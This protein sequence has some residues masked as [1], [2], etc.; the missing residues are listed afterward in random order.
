[1]CGIFALIKLDGKYVSFDLYNGLLA[2]QHRG[3]DSAGIACL[4]EGKIDVVKDVGL[5]SSFFN[6]QNLSALKG[7]AGIAH[8]RYGTVGHT[9]KQDAHPVLSEGLAIAFNG[10]VANY[11]VLKPKYASRMN[12]TCDTEILLFLF[13]DALAGRTTVEAVFEAVGEVMKSINGAF[14]VV[15][16]VNGGLLAFRDPHAIM[17]LAMAEKNGVYAFASESVAFDAIGLELTRDVKAGE[18]IYIDSSGKMHSRVILAKKPVAHCMFQW[19]YFARPDSVIDGKSV[20]EARLALGKAL[21][22]LYTKNGAEVVVPVPDTSRTAAQSL[23]EEL[24]L[25]CREGLIK[26]RY[27]GRTFIM[28]SQAVREKAVSVKL[29]TVTPVIKGKEILLVD[30]SIVRGTT[31]KKIVKLVKREAKRVH[32]L[33]TCPPIKSPCV[34]GIDMPSKEELIA[35]SRSIEEIRR[36][37]GADEL[38]YMSVEE[39]KKALDTDGLCTACLTGEYP[40]GINNEIRLEFSDVRKKER[41]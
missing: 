29:N 40:T 27:V 1:M 11:S 30:D 15:C 21:A 18:A 41:C 3:Q 35:S 6:E 4:Y 24:A 12:S 17:P 8:V 20:Y 28:P 16:L 9:P 26:N 32:L 23:A 2:L 7:N 13:Q 33:S 10:N 38:T 37:L 31:S 22:K 19:V 36:E 39:L 14:S 5:A 34:Y 25:P